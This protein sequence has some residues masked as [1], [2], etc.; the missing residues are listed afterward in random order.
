VKNEQV[1]STQQIDEQ[2][3]WHLKSVSMRLLKK[4][5]ADGIKFQEQDHQSKNCIPC[6]EG[7]M[8]KKPAKRN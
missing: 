4:G 7:K 2:L 5:L 1:A 3:L 6:L 8:T